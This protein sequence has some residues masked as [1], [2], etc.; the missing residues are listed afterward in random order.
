VKVFRK[1][2]AKELPHFEHLPPT[3]GFSFW[4]AGES[5]PVIGRFTASRQTEVDAMIAGG[6][7]KDNEI[8]WYVAQV[9]VARIRGGTGRKVRFSV[10]PGQEY[11]LTAVLPNH[12]NQDRCPLC[13]DHAFE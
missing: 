8:A 9:G 10:G 3:L 6:P 4:W 5:H 13:L 2:R 1:E 12:P 11:Y 7:W